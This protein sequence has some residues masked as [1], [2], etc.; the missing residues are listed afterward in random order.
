MQTTG[1]II[2]D[3][4]RMGASVAKIDMIGIGRGVVDRGKELGKP[5]IGINVA[6]E[7]SDTKAFVNLRAEAYWMLREDF[8]NGDIDLPSE[9]E[10]EEGAEDLA[11]Q[12]VDIRYKR[13]SQGKIQI[14][15]KDELKRRTKRSSP[16]EADAIMLAFLR[17]I[18]KIVRFHEIQEF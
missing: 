11:A 12:L 17:A 13:T 4:E 10:G 14:E 7:A 3:L 6:S 9:E 5:F 1:N 16:D 2:H 15:S 8:Q 18:E